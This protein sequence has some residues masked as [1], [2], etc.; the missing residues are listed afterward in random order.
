MEK[1]VYI[2]NQFSTKLNDKRKNKVQNLK[3]DL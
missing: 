2:L 3:K 1:I